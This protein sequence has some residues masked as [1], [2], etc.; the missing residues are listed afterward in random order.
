MG[1]EPVSCSG[2]DDADKRPNSRSVMNCVVRGG[3]GWHAHL[4]TLD[5]LLLA[6]KKE[7]D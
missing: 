2:R 4:F 3:G 7:D 5:V 1:R 6:R